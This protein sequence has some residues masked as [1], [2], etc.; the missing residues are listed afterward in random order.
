MTINYFNHFKPTQGEKFWSEIVRQNIIYREYIPCKELQP[1]VACYWT[2]NSLNVITEAVLDRIIPDG[3]MDIIFNLEATSSDQSG[4]VVG[5]MNVPSIR[6]IKGVRNFVGVRFWPGGAIPFLNNS[7]A[8][9]T[10]KLVSLD[11]LWKKDAIALS[12]KIFIEPSPEKR[13]KII[14]AKLK[15]L[16]KNINKEDQLMRYTLHEIFKIKGMIPIKNLAVE[17]G[18]SQRHLS[19]KFKDWIGTNPKSFC[20]IIRFQNIVNQLNNTKEVDWPELALRTGYY[21]QSHLI[22]EFKTFYGQT[23]GQLE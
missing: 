11:L 10:D 23:P 7:A 9:F 4:F 1:Y 2:I 5:M 3:C 8:D 19:R 13:V 21:D 18:I 15:S 17:L 22:R 6:R 14:E 16:L 20:S 12:E